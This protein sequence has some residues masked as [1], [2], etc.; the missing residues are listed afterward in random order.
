MNVQQPQQGAQPAVVQQPVFAAVP[1]MVYQG[2]LD[3]QV[4]SQHELF[5]Q[6]SRPLKSE[7]DCSE[8]SLKTFVDQ[9]TMKTNEYG[10]GQVF[11]I[12]VNAVARNLLTEWGQISLLDVQ[13]HLVGIHGQQTRQHQDSC[14][15]RLCIYNSLTAEAQN[16]VSSLQ[17]TFRINGHISGPVLF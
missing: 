2:F 5:N 15:S 14:M 1:A 8:K 3:Y 10:W 13:Q 12:T 6:G 9:L 17:D 11:T 16:R 7:F 4:K